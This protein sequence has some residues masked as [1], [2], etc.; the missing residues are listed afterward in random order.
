MS[1]VGAKTL[2]V[3]QAADRAAVVSFSTRKDVPGLSLLDHCV[4][5]RMLFLS[6]SRIFALSSNYNTVLIYIVPIALLWRVDLVQACFVH[7]V[8]AF[9]TCD[10]SSHVAAYVLRHTYTYI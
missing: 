10:T 7:S 5:G 4:G 8:L 2:H 1:I 6:L 9:Q 3:W